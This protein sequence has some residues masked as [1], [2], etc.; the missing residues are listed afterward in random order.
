[1]A[2]FVLRSLHSTWLAALL[3]GVAL[4]A[5][6]AGPAAAQAPTMTIGAATG[7]DEK[8]TVGLAPL[9]DAESTGSVGTPARLLYRLPIEPAGAVTGDP[10]K[11]S[12]GF[13][14]L[15]ASIDE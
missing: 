13:A 14:T 11:D 1:M 5:V 3:S 12:F 8:D 4:P 2:R 7:D 9:A 10:E 6:L 15:T